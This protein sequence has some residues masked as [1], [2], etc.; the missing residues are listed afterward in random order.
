M[1]YETILSEKRG[2]IGLITLNRPDALN[3]L[4]GQLLDELLDTVGKMAADARIGA[5]VITGSAKA[6]AA[7]VDIK[8]MQSYEFIDVFMNDFAGG[9]D[10]LAE[11]RKPIIAAVS[12]YA[13]GGGC[14]LA[15]MC[16]FI[17]AGES[18]KFGQPEI[19]LGVIPGM[20]GTQR[21]TRAVGKAKAMDMCLTGR[22]MSAEEAESCG[23]VARVVPDHDV[24]EEAMRAA[25]KI[26]SFSQPAV[27]MAKETV[28]RA[29]ETTLAEGLRFERR[30][31]YSMFA[32]E[33]QKEGM[34]AFAEKRSPSFRNR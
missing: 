2:E 5:M 34:A 28:N 26:A 24:V 6:F 29:F 3:A 17:I 1:A 32:L 11:T 30:I 27:L 16:D 15:M 23:L 10:R 18:A 9:W 7:G 12:G 13:L 8:E 22:L 25:E 33:D 20:G 14:E 19:T 4:N 21:L 31:F